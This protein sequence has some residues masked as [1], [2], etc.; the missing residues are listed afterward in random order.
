ME[1]Q[2][3]GHSGWWLVAP[4]MC[5]WWLGSCLMVPWFLMNGVLSEERKRAPTKLQH[6]IKYREKVIRLWRDGVWWDWPIQH[7]ILSHQ[8]ITNKRLANITGG[9]TKR[10]QGEKILE[11]QEDGVKVV[12]GFF[13]TRKILN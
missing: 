4:F 5:E 12:L 6:L 10:E 11:I 13:L 1:S 9:Q 8:K 7:V 2:S 3:C